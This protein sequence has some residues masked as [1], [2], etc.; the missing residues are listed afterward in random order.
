MGIVMLGSGSMPLVTHSLGEAGAAEISWQSNNIKLERF[1]TDSD[2][3]DMLKQLHVM[4]KALG[5]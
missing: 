3:G 4:A 1:T 2:A 5:T